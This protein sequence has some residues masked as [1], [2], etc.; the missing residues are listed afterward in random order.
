[1]MTQLVMA[2]VAASRRRP[3]AASGHRYW[4]IRS[5]D[6][7]IA[8]DYLGCSNLE[9]RT[10]YG[11]AN[12]LSGSDA[13]SASATA[14][15]T[16]APS[17]AIDADLATFWTTGATAMPAGGH[18]LQIDLGSGA[19]ANVL[20][21]AY[22]VRPDTYRED[23]AELYVDYSDDGTAWTTAWGKTGIPAWAAGETRVFSAPPVN[24]TL[25]EIYLAPSA[26]PE[27]LTPPEIYAA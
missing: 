17:K 2:S 16:Y 14:S 4:R 12:I 6:T 8:G 22:R 20:E 13:A 26:P 21:I 3:V 11:G 18:W 24:L 7:H 25:P 9:L 10:A 15:A 1:M 5:P 19:A 23:P 27:N